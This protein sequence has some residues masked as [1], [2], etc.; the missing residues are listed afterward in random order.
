M[1]FEEAVRRWVDWLYERHRGTDLGKAVFEPH[2]RVREDGGVELDYD[3]I[4]WM[5]LDTGSDDI[6]PDVYRISS[7]RCTA[8]TLPEGDPRR[9][10]M[11]R[12]AEEM[13]T[14]LFARYRP[15]GDVGPYPV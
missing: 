7:L 10:G 14:G 11:L 1:A 5:F 4:K 15:S 9:A 12:E 8:G 6:M 2:S 3:I 13:E